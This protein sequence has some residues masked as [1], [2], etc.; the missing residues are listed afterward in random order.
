MMFKKKERGHDYVTYSRV[1]VITSD[2]G[3]SYCRM[4]IRI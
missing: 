1:I 4:K 2:S 3:G